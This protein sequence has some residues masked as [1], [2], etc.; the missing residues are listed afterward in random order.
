MWQFA[1]QTM[2]ELCTA[3]RT[4]HAARAD[5]VMAGERGQHRIP[6]GVGGIYLI[7]AMLRQ[8]NAPPSGLSPTT[9]LTNALVQSH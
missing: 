4:L 9:K 6:Q 1:K 7:A 3:T 5:V 8:N 2:R